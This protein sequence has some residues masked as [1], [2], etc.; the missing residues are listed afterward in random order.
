MLLYYYIKGKNNIF[1]YKLF[2]DEKSDDYPTT[3]TR[4][5]SRA[6]A[7]ISVAEAMHR[8]CERRPRSHPVSPFPQSYATFCALRRGAG[9]HVSSFPPIGPVRPTAATTVGSICSPTRPPSPVLAPTPPP[10]FPRH[11]KS[12]CRCSSIP[13]QL[14]P[15][16]TLDHSKRQFTP[17]PLT[18][19]RVACKLQH[20]AALHRRPDRVTINPLHPH[21]TVEVPAHRH[22]T[23][24]F[25]FF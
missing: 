4:C 24:F 25:I 10:S 5:S 20:D 9:V 3:A 2:I 6:T 18:R 13:S 17:P 12:T 8:A 21:L 11:G 15:L 16:T 23:L 14:P 1:Y 19:R 22:V 7:E